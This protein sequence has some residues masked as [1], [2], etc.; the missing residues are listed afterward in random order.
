MHELIMLRNIMLA[1][2]LKQAVCPY[3][4]CFQGSSVTKGFICYRH[5]VNLVCRAP[6]NGP[7]I[8]EQGPT[9]ALVLGSSGNIINA[10]DIHPQELTQQVKVLRL[11]RGMS[12]KGNGGGGGGHVTCN[13]MA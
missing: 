5:Y 11:P 12:T 13:A 7:W 10:T 2:G 1:T 8:Q 4:H 6:G 3:W 9:P